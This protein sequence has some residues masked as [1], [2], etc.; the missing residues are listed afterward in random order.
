MEKYKLFSG[1]LLLW[2]I[3]FTLSSQRY[4]SGHI[5]DDIEGNPIPA[6]TVFIAGTTSITTTDAEGY[7]RL[8][9]PGE[10][11]YLL[12]VSHAGYQRIY[13][14]IAPGNESLEFDTFMKIQVLD[15]IEIST[16]ARFRKMDINLFWNSILGKNP[17]EK[18][19]HP[20]NPEAVYYDYNPRTRILTVTC[21]EPLHIVNYETGYQIQYYLDWF[22]HDYNTNNADWEAQSVFTELVPATITQKQRW[23]QSRK[24]VYQVSIT[25]FIKSLYNNSLKKDGFEL[26]SIY[27]VR[28]TY[29]NSVKKLWS[30]YDPFDRSIFDPDSILSNNSID[31][32]KTFDLSNKVFM[33]ICHGNMGMRGEF[34]NQLRG[35]LIR[36]YPDGTYTEKLYL[37][38]EDRISPLLT[39]L[40]MTLPIEYN[41]GN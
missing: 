29:K 40:Y 17:N 27:Y 28:G 15:E 26:M 38:A 25:R 31:N 2:L 34:R 18:T 5:A 3:P 39:G 33:L 35:G 4:I 19:I 14:D 16:R 11:T 7:Y 10:G 6:A 13:K 24:D 37:S 8:K 41:H 1:C 12:V 32:S 22:T 9:I 21:R 20:T 23:E 30:P 36:I